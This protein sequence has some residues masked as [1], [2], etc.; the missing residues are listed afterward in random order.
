MEIPEKGNPPGSS[1]LAPRQVEAELSLRPHAPARTSGR[2]AAVQI[3]GCPLRI[4]SLWRTGCRKKSSPAFRAPFLPTRD[5]RPRFDCKIF[6]RVQRRARHRQRTWCALHYREQLAACR[7]QRLRLA[8]TCRGATGTRRKPTSAPSAL[9]PFSNCK[10]DLV[11]RIV[12]TVADMNGV[13]PRS[14]SD[15]VRSRTPEQLSP[16]EAVLRSFGYL[17]RVTPEDLAAARSGWNWRCKRRRRMPMRGRC[18]RFSAF[19]NAGK[20]SNFKQIP[21]R[22]A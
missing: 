17:E 20:D 9:K 15:A 8:V 7:N 16:Y 13:L 12:S 21:W 19:R 2:G 4:E 11:P 10:D 1:T 3:R 6:Q 5:P 22:A 14:M 18:W